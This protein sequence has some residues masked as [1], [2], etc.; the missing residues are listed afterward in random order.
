MIECCPRYFTVIGTVASTLES[1]PRVKRVSHSNS[2]ED[3][4][5]CVSNL[6][7]HVFIPNAP[8]HGLTRSNAV[9]PLQHMREGLH[10]LGAEAAPLPAFHPRP[11][12]DVCH[13]V[14]ALARA[15]QVVARFAGEFARQA[16]FQHAVDAQGFVLVAV[17]GV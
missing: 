10:L 5:A 4:T 11:R 7:L 1:G 12:L 16:D 13:R 15:G 3:E 9:H 6:L 14:L 2:W 17:D 8:L